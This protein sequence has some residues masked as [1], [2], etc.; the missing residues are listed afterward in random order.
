MGSKEL[1][2]LNQKKDIA[3]SVLKVQALNNFKGSSPPI[4]IIFEAFFPSWP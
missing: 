1:I 3:C 4:L 2:P